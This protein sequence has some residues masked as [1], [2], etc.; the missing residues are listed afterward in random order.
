M[1]SLTVKLVLAFTLV[2]LVGIALVA[3]L[4]AMFTG[5]QI[6]EFFENQNRQALI[7]ELADYYRQNGSW[8]GLQI[9]ANDPNFIQRYNWGFVVLDDLGRVV[10]RSPNPGRI[11]MMFNRDLQ[12]DQ[13]IPITIE[14]DVV[15]T[16][17]TVEFRFGN[18]MPLADQ[19]TR[20]NTTLILASVGAVLA[21]VVL[22]VILARSLTR[23]LRELIA[24]TQK[25][26]AG[27]LEQQVPIRSNDE[28][29]ELAASFNRMSADLTRA[30][31]LRRQMTADIAHELR[32][33]LTVVLG[34]TEALSEGELPPDP[35]TFEI[36][37]DETKR[38]NRL[39]EDL[40]TLSLSDAGELHLNFQNIP[41]AELINRGA[42]ARK[43]EAKN[44]AIEIQTTSESDLPEVY[45]DPDRMIQ[46]LVNLLDNA[47]RYTPA[48]GK[49]TLSAEKT[50]A[51]VAI[52]VRDTGPGIPAEDIQHVFERF[53]RS[54]KSRQREEG[55]TGLG[56][57]ITRSLVEIQGGEISVESNP[58][59]GA[60]FIIELPT[61]I[62]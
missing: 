17:Y 24:A 32:T 2:S 31:D 12:I 56:L 15:G 54:D 55:G 28:L 47:L 42:A 9:L 44:K 25:V 21:S 41:P 35:E 46:V 19:L 60:V 48:G 23:S 11:P 61:A 51:G 58:D 38:L 22:G 37:H 59:E 43:P 20:L 18:R 14:G 45:V 5:N 62:T 57:A 8:Q 4:A 27:E 29:G 10:L 53:Y 34:H 30:R 50:R 33:P 7:A 26:A 39:V 52:T 36:I 3:I 16:Y 13:G 49:V 1:R 6:R 40:R